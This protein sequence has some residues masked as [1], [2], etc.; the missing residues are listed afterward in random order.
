MRA[1]SIEEILRKIIAMHGL[2]FFE[3]ENTWMVGNINTSDTTLRGRETR[4]L[5]TVNKKIP[6]VL[7]ECQVIETAQSTLQELGF[8]YGNPPGHAGVSISG[9]TRIVPTTTVI[10][11]AALAGVGKAEVLARPSIM[12]LSGEEANIQI[13]SRVPFAVPVT[14]TGG[15]LQWRV[16]YLD[17]GIALK[18]T[19][20]V[21]SDDSITV[22]LHPEISSIAEWRMTEAGEF[23]VMSTRQADSVV[24]VKNQE[25]ILIGGLL[26]ETERE[27]L[28]KLPFLGDIP[29]LGLPFQNLTMEKVKTEVVFLITPR[30]Q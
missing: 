2:E 18:I 9:N 30:I 1:K 16:E 10:Q 29:I 12:V 22:D 13:G 21:G 5:E 24:R 28:T 3:G 23:P 6:Q 15:T 14:G 25:T 26:S 19:P 7:L 27:N 17:A 8:E 20:H 4:I 11:I